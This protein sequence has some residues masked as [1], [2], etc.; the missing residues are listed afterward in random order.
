MELAF[1]AFIKVTYP[2]GTCTCTLDG[3]SYSHS[4]GG[5]ATFVVNKKGM[6]TIQATY[7][8]IT[9]SSYVTVSTQGE[10]QTISLD[11]TLTLVPNTAYVSTAWTKSNG[12]VTPSST[13]TKLVLS[14]A[15]NNTTYSVIKLDVS[16]YS[17]LTIK[18]SVSNTSSSSST[19]ILYAG[20]FSGLPS[21]SSLNYV[22]GFE[23]WD[24]PAGGSYTINN[25]YDIS[26]L[27]GEYYFGVASKQGNASSNHTTTYNFTNVT[28]TI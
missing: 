3:I 23:K 26:N 10:T 8:N 25:T 20:M 13:N 9:K 5:T 12:S 27:N 7:K 22:T 28:F 14:T 24:V 11:Y 4:G 1:E 15:V 6:W 2:M 19:I 17:T 21:S 16:A 18:G